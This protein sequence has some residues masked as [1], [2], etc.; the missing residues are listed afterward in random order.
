[1]C[2]L[3]FIEIGYEIFHVTGTQGVIEEV[4]EYIREQQK[5]NH[6]A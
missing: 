2:I 4:D 3:R 6:L 1:M 5:N